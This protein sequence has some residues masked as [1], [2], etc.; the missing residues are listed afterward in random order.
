MG[1]LVLERGCPILIR[2]LVS[3]VNVLRRTAFA[4]THAMSSDVKLMASQEAVWTHM[5]EIPAAAVKKAFM[6]NLKP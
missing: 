6:F 4:N 1:L 3:R 5:G 2:P